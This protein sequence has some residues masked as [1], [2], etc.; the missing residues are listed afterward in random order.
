MS[1]AMILQQAGILDPTTLPRYMEEVARYRQFISRKMD[2]DNVPRLEHPGQ[3][4]NI[5]EYELLNVTEN[6]FRPE[7]PKPHG[8]HSPDIGNT[9]PKHEFDRIT[10]RAAIGEVLYPYAIEYLQP[11]NISKISDLKDRTDRQDIEKISNLEKLK[12]NIYQEL[13]SNIYQDAVGVISNNLSSM[14]LEF[15]AQIKPDFGVGVDNVR[16]RL[17]NYPITMYNYR[18]VIID[19]QFD[20]HKMASLGLRKLREPFPEMIFE[21][22]LFVGI[23]PGDIVN[24]Y[25]TSKNYLDAYL[26]YEERHTGK[27]VDFDDEVYKGMTQE[28]AI[29]HL[30]FL[31]ET[32]QGL[33]IMLQVITYHDDY[34][35]L[36]YNI[37][38]T[39]FE[40]VIELIS[41]GYYNGS[42]IP[43]IIGIFE[44]SK[45][46][47]DFELWKWKPE[48]SHFALRVKNI[49]GHDGTLEEIL[50]GVRS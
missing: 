2:F 13:E 4:G 17:S 50:H 26:D 43:N 8:N 12:S 46:E 44:G 28:A 35:N 37:P 7:G 5:F 16:I 15:Y 1:E 11:L 30:N 10:S 38:V 6:I 22:E 34:S 9:I 14:L 48:A 23:L 32:L 45:I 41:K 40:E 18:A 27:E 21:Q 3:G 19:A 31:N 29:K 47:L 49:S 25:E 20:N 39:S 42:D 24:M 33:D 36:Q